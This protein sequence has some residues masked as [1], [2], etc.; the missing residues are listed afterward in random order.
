MTAS[1]GKGDQAAIGGRQRARRYDRAWQTTPPAPS[2]CSGHVLLRGSMCRPSTGRFL[3][4]NGS[5]TSTPDQGVGADRA[6]PPSGEV[7]PRRTVR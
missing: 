5:S 1:R 6:D 4:V 3:A 2:A 7:F